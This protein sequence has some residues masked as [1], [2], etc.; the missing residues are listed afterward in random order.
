MV[1]IKMNLKLSFFV[2]IIIVTTSMASHENPLAVQSILESRDG[3]TTTVFSNGMQHTN[4]Y[5]GSS[6]TRFSN[7]CVNIKQCNGTEIVNYPNNLRAIQDDKQLI[8]FLSAD[9][10]IQREDTAHKNSVMQGNTEQETLPLQ[11]Q[12][13]LEEI[14]LYQ[15]TCEYEEA[16]IQKY[17]C[18][19]LR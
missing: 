12:K 13:E 9:W 3:F 16:L 7:G 8:I 5:D 18:G 11:Q 6:E 2:S 14:Y 4:R 15:D 10:Y 17:L 19:Q 1:P